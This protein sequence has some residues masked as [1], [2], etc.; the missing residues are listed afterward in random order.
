VTTAVPEQVGIDDSIAKWTDCGQ[1]VSYAVMS[2]PAVAIEGEV[3]TA[4]RAP[5]VDEIAD[6]ITSTS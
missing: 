6:L 2:T 5:S 3:K 1:I 4:G